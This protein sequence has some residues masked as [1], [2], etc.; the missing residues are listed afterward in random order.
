[1]LILKIYFKI[2]N[3]LKKT[4]NTFLKI[5]FKHGAE[6]SSHFLDSLH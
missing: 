4:V 5:L 6:T 2:K 3:T 1:M